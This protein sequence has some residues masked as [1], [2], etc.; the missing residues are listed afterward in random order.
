MQVAFFIACLLLAPNEVDLAHQ[1][2]DPCHHLHH[3]LMQKKKHFK[4][5]FAHQAV[6]TWKQLAYC[7]QQEDET[8]VHF[9][10]LFSETVDSTE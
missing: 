9:Y 8:I 2:D 1:V 4:Q 6:S 7:H 10:Q 5:Y 3:H